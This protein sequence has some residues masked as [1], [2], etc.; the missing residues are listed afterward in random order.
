MGPE[1]TDVLRRW[2]G[3]KLAV[4]REVLEPSH[5]IDPKYAVHLIVTM[6]GKTFSGIVACENR[7]IVSLLVNPEAREPTVIE[8]DDIDEM[9][10]TSTSMMPKA[11][12]DR[13]TKDEIFELLAYLL[14]ANPK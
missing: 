3:D 12:L 1:L 4:L 11:L 10:K 7:T 5:R 8:K 14:A 9:V 2:K 13:F 6:E